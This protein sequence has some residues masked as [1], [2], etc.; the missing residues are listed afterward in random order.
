AKMQQW[1][2]NK[3]SGDSTISRSDGSRDSLRKPDWW[4]QMSTRRRT[5]DLRNGDRET[6]AQHKEMMLDATISNATSETTSPTAISP[7][8]TSRTGK[9]KNFFKRKPRNSNGHEKQLYS[10]GSSSQLRTPPTSDPCQSVNSD[11]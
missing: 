8:R 4:R 1:E 9:L 2:S 5:R 6:P 11:E 10:F 7:R 3:I